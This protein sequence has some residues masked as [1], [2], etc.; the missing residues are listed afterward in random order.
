MS[1]RFSIK[2]T[3]GTDKEANV[4]YSHRDGDTIV[5]LACPECKEREEL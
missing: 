3:C 2:C 4:M 1:K 5:T